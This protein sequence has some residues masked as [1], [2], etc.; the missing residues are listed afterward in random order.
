MKTISM[1][2][3]QV[4]FDLHM[5]EEK[6]QNAQSLMEENPE[7]ETVLTSPVVT[8]TE[9]SAVIDRLFDRELK[10]FMKIACE[11]GDVNCLPE[12]FEYYRQLKRQSSQTLKAEFFYVT[13]PG[14]EQLHRIKQYLIKKYQAKQID[15]T[16]TKDVS[17]VGGFVLKVGDY[18]FDSSLK[19][20]MKKLQ[21][22]LTWR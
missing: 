1:T 8:R 2:Y 6:I 20:K 14:E 19:G 7:I 13:K 9:K 3:G 15:L 11:N 17:L 18:V 12:A 22:S 4:L 10:N 5:K 21:Q 16:L